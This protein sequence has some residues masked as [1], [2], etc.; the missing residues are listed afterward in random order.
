MSHK[1]AVHLCVL[2]TFGGFFFVVFFQ[3][4]LWL[5]IQGGIV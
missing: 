2:N 4:V 5:T 1:E 3:W